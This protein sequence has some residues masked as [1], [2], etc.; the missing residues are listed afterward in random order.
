[1]TF[2]PPHRFRTAAGGVSGSFSISRSFGAFKKLNVSTSKRKHD[3]ED[4]GNVKRSRSNSHPS[5]LRQQ[6][7]TGQPS[8]KMNTSLYE[9]DSSKHSNRVLGCL[10]ISPAGRALRTFSCVE[11]LLT[12]LRDAIKGHRSL[13]IDRGILHRDVSENNIIITDLTRTNGFGGMLIDLDLAKVVGSRRSGARHQTGTV[14][15]MAIQVLQKAAYT[16]RHDLESFFYVLLWICA[17]RAWDVEFRC[18]TSAR[19]KRSILQ[20]WY[21]GNFEEIAH[22]KQGDMHADGLK[23]ILKEFPPALENVK[24]LCRQIRKILFPLRQ[25]GGLDT[26]THSVAEELYLKIIGAYDDALTAHNIGKGT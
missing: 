25:S 23:D 4:R 8:A 22:S 15:F 18:A 24:H 7:E 1:M 20:T 19:P 6:S 21:T 14:E 11:E 3:W 17:R 5:K 13:Y 2:P 26:G 10:A 16:Y 12:A 9:T